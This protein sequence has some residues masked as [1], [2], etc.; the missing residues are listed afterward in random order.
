MFARLVLSTACCQSNTRISQGELQAQESQSAD[1]NP[2]MEMR[3]LEVM[4][5]VPVKA[6]GGGLLGDSAPVHTV[7]CNLPCSPQRPTV[8]SQ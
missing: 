7:V 2:V 8:G 3:N 5:E 1:S 4:K 6:A